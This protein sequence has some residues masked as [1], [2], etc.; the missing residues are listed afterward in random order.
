MKDSYQREVN[1][2]RLSVTQQ[3]NLNCF[4]CHNEGQQQ[5]GHELSPVEIEALVRVAS[6]L[7]VKNLKLTGGEPLV[8]TDIINIV[9]RVAPYVSDL[10]L[11][12]NGVLLSHYAHQLKDAG[13]S[14]LNISLP[15]T[16]ADTYQT[17]TGKPYQPLVIDG[18]QK[19]AAEGFRLIKIN[20]L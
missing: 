5:N 12:T 9:E 13:L 8:R 10:S 15:S 7:G 18:I 3:C 14:R 1:S 6:G 19:A 16:N 17:I 2:F 20:K 4:Y 11:T